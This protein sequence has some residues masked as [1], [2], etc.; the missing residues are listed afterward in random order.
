LPLTLASILFGAILTLATAYGLGVI[1]LRE[2]PAP[3]EIALGLGAVAESALIF[4]LLCLHQGRRAAFVF[5]GAA[6]LGALRWRRRHGLAEPVSQPLGI[7]WVAA[8]A[9][10]GAYGLWYLVN[11]V[12]PET[13]S[14]GIAYHLGLPFEYVRLHGFPRRVTFYDMVPQGMEMLY[15][16]AFAFGRH[17]AAKLVEFAFFLATV[18]LL[19]RIGRRLQLPD[20]AS[21]AAAAGYFCAPIV[22]FTGSSSY[23]DAAGVF[24][25]L[26][27]FYLLLIW[28]GTGDRRYLFPAGILAGFCYAIK[29]PGALTV[30]AAVAFALA[31]RRWRDA[32]PVA[33]AAALVMAPWLVRAA[34][35]AHNPV[36]PLLNG[37]FPNPYFHVDT[38]QQL[39]SYLRSLP[40]ASP[41]AIVRELVF[42]DRLAGAFGPF[43][44]ALPVGL[45]ALR[46]RGGRWA[47]SAA[48]LLALPWFFDTG[49]RFLM[50]SMACAAIALAMVL[51][52][53]AAWAA[54]A[55]QAVLCWPPLMNWSHR[56]APYRLHDFPWTAALRIVPE[57]RYLADRI[58][59]FSVAQML[60][61]QTAPGDKTLA[62]TSVA[63]AY[64]DR[65]VRVW[66]QSAETDRLGDALR[67]AAFSREGDLFRWNAAWPLI[68]VQALRLV[69]PRAGSTE[70]DLTDV[71]LYTSRNLVSPSPQWKIRAWPN[72]SEAPLALDGNL[73]TRWRSR[74]PVVT[75][76]F[77][78]IR[79][80]RPLLLSQ[81]VVFSH[82]FRPGVLDVFGQCDDGVWRRLG[83]AAAEHRPAERLRLEAGLSLRASGYRYLLAPTGGGGY[84]PVG[85]ALLA[86]PPE[87]GFTF[88]D[89]AGRYCLFRVK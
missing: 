60:E 86:D 31:G 75:G 85:N 15:T 33:C 42:G 8:A 50:P 46:R 89:R 84:A 58:E 26:A 18:P 76:M 1:A 16:V 28:H 10:F 65:D 52:R 55:M 66:W 25:A 27:S 35:V 17:S 83:G 3:P 5:I 40:S 20:T 49:A 9:V 88:L 14:D 54:I 24:F 23:N 61:R 48:A 6:V 51:P 63:H 62:L 69:P 82:A 57:P 43:L 81:A 53:P 32:R 34:L 12:A 59:E 38:E 37:V 30:L 19:F 22:G 41:T 4:L 74:R 72:P 70:F 29:F 79:F 2:L 80:D 87:W 36:A 39:S 67:A 78:E 71:W 64:L 73:L 47:W 77:L 7:G 21:L 68:S 44:L 56:P 13:L 45:L 11:A